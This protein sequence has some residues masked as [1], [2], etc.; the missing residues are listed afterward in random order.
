MA[1][2]LPASTTGETTLLVSARS[3]AEGREGSDAEFD[4]AELASP[5]A[6]SMSA[7]LSSPADESGPRLTDV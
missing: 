5:D 2:G 7:K 3:G 1:A 4:D 6:A